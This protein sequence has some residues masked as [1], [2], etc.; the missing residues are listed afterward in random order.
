LE[1]N[2]PS[3]RGAGAGRGALQGL[4]QAEQEQIATLN[5]GIRALLTQEQATIFDATLLPPPG[6]G[7]KSAQQ[8]SDAI[9]RE[10]LPI[11]IM[12]ISII[13]TIF[14][15]IHTMR[16]LMLTTTMSSIPVLTLSPRMF[17]RSQLHSTGVSRSVLNSTAT[18]LTL[19][20]QPRMVTLRG[21]IPVTR[22][23]RL[24]QSTI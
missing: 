14:T 5:A 4:E 7:V 21:V 15:P 9:H 22:K 10:R 3:T 23:R 20:A 6:E 2:A 17:T 19:S 24:T 18:L 1:A 12:H 11:A 8:S 16:I 13:T